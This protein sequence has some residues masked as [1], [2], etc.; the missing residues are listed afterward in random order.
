MEAMEKSNKSNAAIVM[1]DAVGLL[2][3]Q[4]KNTETKEINICYSSNHAMVVES[5][6]NTSCSWSIKISKEAFDKSRLENN[7]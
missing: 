4:A 5:D 3:V 7:G 1:E 2:H 6:Q